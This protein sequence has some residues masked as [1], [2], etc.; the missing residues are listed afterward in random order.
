MSKKKQKEKKARKHKERAKQNVLARREKAR[1]ETRQQREDDRLKRKY[2]I[3][4]APIRNT[5]ELKRQEA[6][7]TRRPQNIVSKQPTFFQKGVDDRQIATDSRIRERLEHNMQIL[8]A[9]EAAMQAEDENR[10]Q[11][12]E[13]L[14]GEG[15]DTMREKLDA[16]GEKAEKKVKGNKRR[17]DRIKGTAKAKM[18]S[19][20]QKRQQKKP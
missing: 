20:G 7:K 11:L 8:E 3:K 6:E 4:V 14:E 13:Q 16:I 2:E 17:P 12:Q 15:H 9:L 10:K 18:I 19:K 1:E 5:P